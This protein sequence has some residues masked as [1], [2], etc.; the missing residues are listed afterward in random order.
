[1]VEGLLSLLNSSIAQLFKKLDKLFVEFFLLES[2][3]VFRLVPKKV[4]CY[5]TDY[6][7]MVVYDFASTMETLV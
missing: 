1:M 3:V 5:A 2:L 7:D 6:S 4:I